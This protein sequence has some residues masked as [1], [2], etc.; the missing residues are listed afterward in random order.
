MYWSASISHDYLN[1]LRH[2]DL[3]HLKY[4]KQLQELGALNRTAVFFMSDHGMRFGGIRS[5]YLGMLEERLPY[6]ML[7]LPP[8]F[9]NK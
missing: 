8:W 9:R 4:L 2:A 5:T 7:Y 3:P 6:V 1:L